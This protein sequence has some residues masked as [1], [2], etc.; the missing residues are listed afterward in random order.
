LSAHSKNAWLAFGLCLT[1]AGTAYAAIP[2]AN[3]VIHGCYNVITGSARIIDGNSCNLLEKAVTW[4]QIGPRGPAG[5]TGA[6]GA[7]GPQGP[8]GAP[9]ITVGHGNVN[10]NTPLAGQ[11]SV[12]AYD[13]AVTIT[14]PS[15]GYCSL[16]V[17]GTM[18]EATGEIIL[19]PSTLRDDGRRTTYTQMAYMTVFDYPLTGSDIKFES[20]G[21]TMETVEL[22]AGH[23]YNF[24]VNVQAQT[25]ITIVKP[26]FISLAWFCRFDG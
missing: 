3:G 21:T 22:D 12:H 5:A 14:A 2:D 17:S 10:V 19:R 23:S 11:A 16:T 9:N 13:E 20:A 26:V 24:G 18:L 4:Q 8:A 1:A 7:Q 15:H 6:Q 25:P